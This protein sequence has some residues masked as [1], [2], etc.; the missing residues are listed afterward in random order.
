MDTK[1]TPDTPRCQFEPSNDNSF[2]CVQYQTYLSEQKPAIQFYLPHFSFLRFAGTNIEPP[3]IS[4]PIPWGEWGSPYVRW[5]HGD[6]PV[7]LG[8]SLYG[9]RQAFFDEKTQEV[10]V[11]DLNSRLR[12]WVPSIPATSLPAGLV[13]KWTTGDHNR[14][15]TYKAQRR[16]GDTR[17]Q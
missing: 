5:P 6:V 1:I 8:S 12:N 16:L 3:Q 14:A 15:G 2:V 9:S 10:T 17:Q 11:L 4:R 13:Q 7:R